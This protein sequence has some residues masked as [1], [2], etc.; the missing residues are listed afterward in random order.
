MSECVEITNSNHL[1]RQSVIA[2]L[3]DSW[4][5]VDDPLQWILE[6]RKGGPRTKATGWISRS[7]CASKL[8]L[9]RCIPAYCGPVDPDALA[10]VDALPAFHPDGRKPR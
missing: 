5:I 10:V 6:R 7:F 3:N 1:Q 8:G 9:T 2:N 4:R